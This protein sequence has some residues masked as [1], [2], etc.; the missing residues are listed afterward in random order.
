M[1]DT[2]F[3]GCGGCSRRLGSIAI[4]LA[5]YRLPA[6]GSGPASFRAG[7]R[8]TLPAVGPARRSQRGTLV[9]S[10]RSRLARLGS[11]PTRATVI[12][13]LFV[14]AVPLLAVVVLSLGN[15][16][17][18]SEARVV[19]ERVALARVVAQRVD[20]VVGDTVSALRTVAQTEDVV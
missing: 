7:E 8:A 4:S 12:G 13:L 19:E 6:T 2:G 3:S 16:Q 14:T 17:Q 1:I 15:A 10:W 20:A 9:S 5:F 18:Q 11:R